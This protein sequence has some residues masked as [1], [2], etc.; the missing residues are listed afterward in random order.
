MLI[1]NTLVLRP[2][3][4]RETALCWALAVRRSDGPTCLVL[5]RQGLDTLSTE[6]HPEL[7]VDMGAYLLRKPER[8]DVTLV[9]SGSEVNLA[10]DSAKALEQKGVHA[11]VV[12]MPSLE[13]FFDQER[14]Y[15]REVLGEAPKVII[16]AGTSFGLHKLDSCALCITQNRF[17]ASA[18]GGVNGK[19]FG[20][21]V[22]NVVERVM[23][24]IEK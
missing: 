24:H 14:E 9:A 5:T 20:F 10:L 11:A 23:D 6:E 12:S 13:L 21:T 8:R 2:A 17:G 19:K 1:P 3:D 4:A 16:E 15:I 7:A 18:P 22:E